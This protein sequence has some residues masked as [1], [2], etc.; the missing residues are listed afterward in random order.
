[1]ADRIAKRWQPYGAEI[2]PTVVIIG[3]A[4]QARRSWLHLQ[5]WSNPAAPRACSPWRL[6]G[7]YHARSRPWRTWPHVFEADAE[8]IIPLTVLPN[9]AR[10]R[11]FEDLL[12]QL[13]NLNAALQAA[14]AGTS[15]AL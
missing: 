10:D 4:D 14:D 1:M 2:T 6:S 15:T 5:A 7:L 8:A 11:I 13:K 12:E 9:V 3:E